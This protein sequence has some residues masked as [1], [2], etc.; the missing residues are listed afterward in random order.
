MKIAI[1]APG[2]VDRS[3]EYRVIPA[4]LAYIERAARRHEVHV[5][6]L[7]QEQRAA[8]WSLCGAYIHNSGRSFTDLR[9]LSYVVRQHRRRPFDVVHS[10][11]AGRCGYLA[12]AAGR[13]I[14]RPCLVH[15]AGGELCAIPSIQYGGRLRT[16]GRAREHWVLRSADVLT[17]ASKQIIEQAAAI[18]FKAERV[19][20]GVDL[21]KWPAQPIRERHG[22]SLRLIHV[23]SL[24]RVKDQPTLLRAMSLLAPDVQWQLDIVGEDTLSGRMQRLARDLQ[25]GDR[26]RFH[27]FLTQ[28]Q[29]YP[30]MARAHIN[31][32]TSMHEA[33][34]LVVMEA[35]IA[36]IP[37]VGTSVGHIA[38]WAPHAA[39][40]VKIAD[41]NGLANAI[42]NL[43]RDESLRQR[44]AREAQTRAV[45]ENADVT[46]Q[47]F[48]DLYRSM[49]D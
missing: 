34:P 20:L 17:A 23:A 1:I 42:A 8:E 31:L 36:G 41:A 2:G 19:P 28:R 33:G 22:N 49:C 29:L 11:W 10:F 7:F 37:S 13:I 27:G 16:L 21:S 6:T 32:I 3:G 38:G 46:A 39:S 44:I 24:N 30:L 48:F 9:T 4:L 43:Y 14:R 25:L 15:L 47:R 35:A 26:V 45:A 12:I 40:A 5:F 18:G